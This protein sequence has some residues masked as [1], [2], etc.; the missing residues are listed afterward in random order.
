VASFS[1]HWNVAN[2][3]RRVVSE[4]KRRWFIRDY[5]APWHG[6]IASG[7]Q[8]MAKMARI[9]LRERTHVCS[10]DTEH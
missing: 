10:E 8:E 3:T 6:A 4:L 7:K 1:L 2:G 5:D 9:T